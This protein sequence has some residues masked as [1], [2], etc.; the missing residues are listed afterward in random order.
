MIRKSNYILKGRKIISKNNHQNRIPNNY[1]SVLIIKIQLFKNHIRKKNLSKSKINKSM[2]ISQYS[3]SFITNKFVDSKI[4]KIQVASQRIIRITN[5]LIYL[6]IKIQKIFFDT[7]IELHIQIFHI[8][9]I[10][11]IY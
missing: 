7:K 1:Y 8:C 3:N 2:S 5:L 4:I 9:P 11:L 6:E 10:T